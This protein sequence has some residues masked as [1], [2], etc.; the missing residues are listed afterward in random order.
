[1]YHL[2]F[3]ARP[4]PRGVLRRCRSYLLYRY[5][6]LS[7][8]CAFEIH[9]SYDVASGSERHAIR[10]MKKL[11]VYRFSGNDMTPITTLRT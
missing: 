2:V 9:L 1:M 10:L 4:G 7:L 6:C 5:C 3:N 11:V 8:K